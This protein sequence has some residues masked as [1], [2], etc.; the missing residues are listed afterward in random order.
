MTP[1]QRGALEALAGR[2]LTTAE[3]EQITPLVAAEPRADAQ[4]AA[5]LSVGRTRVETGLVITTRGAASRF[6]A[7]APLTG[8]LAFEAAMLALETFAAQGIQSAN[9]QTMLTARAVKRQLVAFDERGLDFGD[10]VLRGMLDSFTVSEPPLLTGAQVAGFKSLA[11]VA[12][13]VSERAVTIAL[14]GA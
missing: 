10:P 4:I 13:P 5:I 2:A 3:V 1:N 11:N 12:D 8:P 6:P 7:A 9:P 14:N